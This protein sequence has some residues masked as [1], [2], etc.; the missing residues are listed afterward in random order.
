MNSFLDILLQESKQLQSALLQPAAD[1]DLAFLYIRAQDDAFRAVL[2]QP[3]Q[4]E[5][6]VFYCHGAA[7]HL[8]GAA[9]EGNAHVFIRL[10][11]AAEVDLQVGVGGDAVQ[12]PVVD[13]VLCLGA[14]QVDQVQAAD[15]VGLKFLG[16]FQRVLVVDFFLSI[17]AFRQADALAVDDV[18]GGDDVHEGWLI[19]LVQLVD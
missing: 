7:G 18:Y 2:L 1:G 15:A 6:R 8:P 12:Y 4:E 13:D 10:K 16:Y 11:A 5:L 3:A 17:V 9:F 19:E 14:I